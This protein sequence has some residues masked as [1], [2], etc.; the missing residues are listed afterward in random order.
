MAKVK[1]LLVLILLALI[2]S[3]CGGGPKADAKKLTDR[4]PVEVFT[5]VEEP[6]DENTPAEEPIRLWELSDD[7]TQLSIETQTNYGYSTIV[8]EGDN[9]L[10]DVKAYITVWVH[11][12]ESAADV[13]LEATLLDWQLQGVRFDSVR[14]GRDSFDAGVIAGGQLY[15]YQA[16]SKI[17]ELR[18]IPEA[19]GTEI[20]ELA[21]ERLLETILL[22]LENVD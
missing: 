3:A 18:I 6:E 19:L 22:V 21:S 10:E 20:P 11:A 13:A 4:F 5:I 1:L 17:I 2:V 7:Q 8:Y 9:D 16:E 15:I 12:N 14:F